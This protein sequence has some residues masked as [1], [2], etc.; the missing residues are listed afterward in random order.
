VTTVLDGLPE[1]VDP[2]V[3]I[4]GDLPAVTRLVRR[5][6]IVR[7]LAD[8]DVVLATERSPDHAR[9]APPADGPDVAL[10]HLPYRPVEQRADDDPLA[11]VRSA[12]ETLTPGR[13]AVVLGPADLLIG[14]LP[15]YRSAA[16]TRNDLLRTGRVEAIIQLPGGLLPFRPGYRTALWVLR[17]ENPSPWQ[18]RVLLA[19]VSGG[20][21]TEG[22]VR[23]LVWD[24]TTWRRQGYRPDQHL[25]AH[26]VQVEVA[27]LLAPRMAL[28]AR[29]PLRL[30][31]D[32]GGAAAAVARV[33][34]IE[35]ELH[36]RPA[37]TPPPLHT[38]LE[39]IDVLPA[40][41]DRDSN[42]YATLGGRAR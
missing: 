24:V 19:D 13:T 14:P 39:T 7:G 28:T 12:V 8:S 6:L 34:A 26:A 36:T 29:G 4:V 23:E 17:H 31:D 41:K 9:P 18:G 33:R 3:E 42:C 37:V 2:T 21:L 38:G 35:A 20:P 15:P 27:T 5:R 25:R 32:A 40:L 22:V 16:R 10:V 1:G 30:H 11:S